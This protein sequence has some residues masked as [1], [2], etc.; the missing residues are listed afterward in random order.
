MKI[1]ASLIKDIAI[2][3]LLVLAIII[4][5]LVFFYDKLAINKVV[6]V[7]QPYEI[8]ESVLNEIEQENQEQ[9]SDIV[10]TYSIDAYDLKGYEGTKKSEYNKDKIDPFERYTYTEIETGNS[11]TITDS[12]NENNEKDEEI[13]GIK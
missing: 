2:S 1:E 6:S 7:P 13:V 12:N 5:F 11:N 10:T 4:I 3:L 9:E 8:S